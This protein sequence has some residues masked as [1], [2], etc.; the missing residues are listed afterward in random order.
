MYSL[1][2]SQIKYNPW[3][4][5]NLVQLLQKLNWLVDHLNIYSAYLLGVDF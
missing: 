5:P 3:P 4:P 1:Y 2:Y